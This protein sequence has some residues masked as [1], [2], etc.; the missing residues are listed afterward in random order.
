MLAAKQLTQ[1]GRVADLALSSA[2]KTNNKTLMDTAAAAKK[3]I[4]TLRKGN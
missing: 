1:A 2:R 3:R 4:E